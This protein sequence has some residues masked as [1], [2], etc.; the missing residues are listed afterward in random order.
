MKSDAYASKLGSIDL[1]FPSLVDV[2]SLLIGRVSECC[3]DPFKT[4]LPLMPCIDPR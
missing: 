4:E 2:N 1:S 3:I